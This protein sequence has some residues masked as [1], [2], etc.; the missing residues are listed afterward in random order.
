MNISFRYS[1]LVC[2]CLILSCTG[3]ASRPD[4]QIKLAEDA[5]NQALEQF[6]EQYAP[7]E[8]KSAKEIWDQAQQELADERFSAAAASFTTAKARLLKATEVAKENRASMQKTVLD[9]QANIQDSYDKF[10][11]DAS[12]AKLSGAARK[13]YETACADIDKR[14]SLI[15]TQMQ[16]G[17]FIGAKD[18][19]LGALQAIDYAGKKLLPGK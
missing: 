17:D 9:Y 15:E 1:L 6:A 8:W 16:Q 7:D 10:K 3:C 5:M 18:N 11:S 12:G 2:V 14:I 4:E 19:A 13:E